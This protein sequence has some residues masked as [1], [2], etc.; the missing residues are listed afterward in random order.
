VR[1]H[2]L[3]R[4]Q[5]IEHLRRIALAQH[6]QI[7]QLVEALARKCTELEALKGSK[8]G[9][10]RPRLVCVSDSRPINVVCPIGG[11]S[12]QPDK[13]AASNARLHNERPARR[14]QRRGQRRVKHWGSIGVQRF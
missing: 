1:E 2:E 10:S 5:D 6:A 7:G 12:G 4:E 8:N 9:R 13:L 14:L 3:E 11:H